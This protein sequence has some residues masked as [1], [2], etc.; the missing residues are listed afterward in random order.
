MSYSQ[1]N[2]YTPESVEQMISDLREEI[3]D[4]FN[5]TYTEEQFLGTGWYKFIYANVQKMQENEIKLAEI[6]QKLQ[7][8]ITLTNDRIQRPSVSYPGLIDSFVDNGFT[9]S[10]KAP[11]VGDAGKIYICVDVDDSD[12]DYAAT[13]LQICGL[14]RDFVAAGIESQGTEEELITLSNGQSFY[15]RFNL[16][17]RTPVLLRMTATRSDNTQITLPT[18]EA[19]RQTILDNINARYRL[20]Y[21]FE[22]QRYYNFQDAPWAATILLEWSDD[23]GVNWH[24]GVFEAAY[25]DIFDID[26]EDIEVVIS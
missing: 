22:P 19:I 15:F 20:G 13:K 6:F 7:A 3:N 24:S 26:L 18:D 11:E 10:V 16:P 25:D 4:V 8:Y 12:P 17:D 21:D 2:G 23:D 14:I 1:D 5:L 9:S